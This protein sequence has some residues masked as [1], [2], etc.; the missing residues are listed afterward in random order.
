MNSFAVRRAERPCLVDIP[1]F[2]DERGSLGVVELS[3]TVGFEA[4][5]FYYLYGTREGEVRG[6][7]CHRNL[8]QLL[9]CLGGRVRVRLEDA[10]GQTV[11]ELSDP[12]Q[13]LVIPPGCWRELDSFSPDTVV[14]VLASHEYDEGDYIRD[15]EQFRR[16][17]CS[18]AKTET[19]PYIPMDRYH[20]A[21]GPD[22]E[23]AALAA[24][25]SQQFI[26]GPALQEFEVSFARY[27]GVRHVVGCGNG[28]DAL[29]LIL[30]ALEIGPGDEVVVPAN[31][32]FASA[33]AVDMAGAKPVFADV[34]PDTHGLTGETLEK[35]VTSRTRAV[36]PVH[37]YGTPVDMDSLGP[38]A[39]RHNLHVIEDAAQAHGARFGNTQ[40]GAF[41]IAAGFSFYPTKNLGAYGDAGAV[42][43][44][45]DAL[46]A[47]IRMLGNYGS[48]VKYHHEIMG[49]NSRLDPLQASLLSVKLKHL[50]TW[51][52]RRRQLAQIY[53][54]GLDGIGIYGLPAVPAKGLSVWHVF[55]LRI[56]SGLR[57]RCKAWLQEKGVGTN[58]H[59]PVPIHLQ[60][61]YAGLQHSRGDF[62]VSEQSSD[63][64]LSLPLDPFHTEEEIRTVVRHLE[65][66]AE[67]KA[68]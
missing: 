67:K 65:E 26:G 4:R 44:N 56:R 50:E 30:R 54:E 9:I 11:F 23:K 60:P 47:R 58:I 51:N 34:D 24:L 25:R 18:P 15:Y 41:G 37:L 64:L 31:S 14:A 17:F 40:C 45:D 1:E 8:Y 2:S 38:V 32:F 66:F 35:A 43:T 22:L 42:A 3:G 59:Y 39:A 5:R 13:G 16:E 36:M 10:G 28:L 29:V 57:D 33:L 20:R 19:V 7:H 68:G 49:T 46:A 62:P 61:V 63:E 48:K 53:L 55:P 27:L 21:I 6:R 52:E 12:Q